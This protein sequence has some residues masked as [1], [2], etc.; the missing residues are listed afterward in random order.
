MDV[1]HWPKFHNVVS[2]LLHAL[3]NMNTSTLFVLFWKYASAIRNATLSFD[4]LRCYEQ[5]HYNDGDWPNK[6]HHYQ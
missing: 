6:N 5:Y 1:T 4:T 2:D 3:S